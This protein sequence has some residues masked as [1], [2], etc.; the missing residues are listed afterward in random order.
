LKAD[1][2][3]PDDFDVTEEALE[4]ALGE[5]DERMRR[6]AESPRTEHVMLVIDQDILAKFRATGS[7]WQDRINDALRA[8]S[9]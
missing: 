9:I 1:P 5:R 6:A 7:G 2:N 4:R 8:A 3:D